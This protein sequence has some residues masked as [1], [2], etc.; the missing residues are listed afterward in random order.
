MLSGPVTQVVLPRL[1]VLN[2]EADDAALRRIYRSATA[3]ITALVAPAS[4]I[5][6]LFGGEIMWVWTGDRGIAAQ[7]APILRWYSLGNGLLALTAFSYYLQFAHGDLRLH[8]PRQYAGSS[9]WC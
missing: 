7:A 6:A 8:R 9:P 3:F 2:A 4:L 1:T 5:L